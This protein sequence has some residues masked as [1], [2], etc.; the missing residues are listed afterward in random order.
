M[1][2]LAARVKSL[3]DKSLARDVSDKKRASLVFDSKEA[4]MFDR[5]MVFNFGKE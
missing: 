4:A 5:D 2:T 1:T 3:R